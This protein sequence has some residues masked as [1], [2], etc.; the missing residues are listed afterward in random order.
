M[1]FLQS[2]YMNTY[3]AQNYIIFMKYY[4]NVHSN[5]FHFG[6]LEKVQILLYFSA[7][8]FLKNRNSWINYKTFIDIVYNKK[9][10]SSYDTKLI[11]LIFTGYL[12]LSIFWIVLSI[13][14]IKNGINSIIEL[15]I[16]KNTIEKL[17]LIYSTDIS[18]KDRFIKLQIK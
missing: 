14:K 8:V 6:W 18:Y 3:M 15:Y 4:N 12:F 1:L 7:K 13:D 11:L 10:I 2:L 5:I 16:N 17:L 9:S